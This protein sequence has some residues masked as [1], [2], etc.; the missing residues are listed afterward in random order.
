[1]P[2]VQSF[3]GQPLPRKPYDPLAV[4][5]SPDA[6]RERLAETLTLAERLRILLDLAER[7]RLPLVSTSDLTA[8]DQAKGG[9]DDS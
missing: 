2:S 3:G 5:P 9:R 8:R 7:L 6:L 1:M 4:I